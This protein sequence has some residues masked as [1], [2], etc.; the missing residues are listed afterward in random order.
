V[1]CTGVSVAGAGSVKRMRT[2][3]IANQKGGCGKT[4]TAINLAVALAFRGSRVL[5][6]DLDPQACATQAL[7][8]EPDA[9][10]PT[11][12]HPLV[13]AQI[14]MSEAL[15]HTKVERLDLVPSNVSLA[16]AEM[17]LV[18]KP[19]RELR[20]AQA[21]RA[22]RDR[23]ECC[24]ID[25][26]PSLGVL[27]LNA[28]VVSTDVI[29][30]IQVDSYAL[31]CAQRLLETVLIVRQRFHRYC[32]GNLRILL[33]CVDDKTALGRRIQ[34]QIR[35]LFGDLVLKTVIHRSMTMAEALAA[36]QAA[37]TYAPASAAA[38]EYEELA[39]ELV[40]REGEPMAE[41]KLMEVAAMA[42]SALASR[43]TG[44]SQS[45]T[46]RV[47]RA[48]RRRVPQEKSQRQEPPVSPAPEGPPRVRHRV[49]P[50][51]AP[52]PSEPIV[53]EARKVKAA[54]PVKR[55]KPRR[56]RLLEEAS[57]SHK[58]AERQASK[59]PS[60]EVVRRG[61]SS[62]QSADIANELSEPLVSEALDESQMAG[63]VTGGAAFPP[64]RRE[65][66]DHSRSRLRK[67]ILGVLALAA[68]VVIATAGVIVGLGMMNKP[69]V[70]TLGSV[71][72]KEDTPLPITLAGTD[73]DRDQ[74][75]YR[76]VKDP[77]HG[78]LNGTPPQMI[79]TPESNYNGP[80]S[81]VF[82]ANDGKVDSS[83][84]TV[85]IVVSPTND[86]PV[87]TAQS[88]KVDD[89]K[90]AAIVLTANDI[91]ADRLKFSIVS[92]PKRGTLSLDPQFTSDGKLVY[93]P[94]NGF[95]GADSFTFK[96]ND[97]SVDSAPATVSMNVA[98]VNSPPVAA[99]GEV[100]AQEDTPVAI[101]LTATDPDKDPL[102][103]TVTRGPANGTLDGAAPKLRYVPKPG[104]HGNDT[105]TYEARDSQGATGDAMVTI[106]VAPVNHSPSIGSEPLTAAVAGRQYVYDVN[107][108]DR[109]EGDKLAYTLV[110]K[111]DGMSI[112]PA[113]G[114]IQWV[115]TEAQS[116]THKVV[117]EV[118]DNAAA[119]ATGRQSFDVTVGPPTPQKTIL[120][121]SGAYDQRSQKAMTKDNGLRQVQAVDDEACQIQAGSYT[122]FDFANVAIPAGAKI[123]S[124][125]LYINHFEEPQFSSGKLEWKVGTGWPGSPS[126]WASMTPSV[127]EG[128]R[129]KGTLAWDL[130]GAVDTPEKINGLQLQ[131]KNNCTSPQKAT[132][133]D[134]THVVVLWQ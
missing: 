12:Y 108:T 66:V 126:S 8:G 24:V 100:A 1:P 33:S 130:K 38:A 87:A 29:V 118:A 53:P 27:T 110:E 82:V 20:L 48:P 69:P 121:V 15:V 13:S 9:T 92:Q 85:S 111:P 123:T 7:S 101:T 63:L 56:Q 52:Q 46:V 120:A 78:R 26:P 50:Q 72:A 128:Q 49:R 103:Y 45:A 99:D 5:I 44:V 124:V 54:K 132:F 61:T 117:V 122:I 95:T 67:V 40:H 83:P 16:G 59:P 25:C 75:T 62:I 42:Q 55:A 81:F 80:D 41:E 23:Y 109:D 76:V 102:T 35:E 116:G 133:I 43:E 105:L 39:E 73:R 4:T 10:G 84:A 131:V 11:V 94:R 17:E 77:S 60:A 65:P 58:R 79:Y 112:D 47:R 134:H 107:A 74:L 68:V 129:N 30:P 3:A 21:F 86:I 18:G 6:V 22:V 104:F 127:Y 106:R 14:P 125:V 89:N 36:G 34:Q 19:G 64:R 31:K 115:P 98:H 97:G 93:T 90:A 70:A 32:A 51:A 57:Q 28:L 2:I 114:H 91:D 96:V 113:S 119:P 37:M 71:T 88:V